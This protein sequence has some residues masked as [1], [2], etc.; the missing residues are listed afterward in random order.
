MPLRAP[1]MYGFIFGFHRLVWWPKWTPASSRF[2]MVT[3]VIRAP[4]YP[5]LLSARRSKRGPIPAR[6]ARTQLGGSFGSLVHLVEELL[7][8]LGGP[9]LV[10][11]ELHRLDRIQLGEQLAQDPDAIQHVA[12]QE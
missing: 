4:W 11:Q 9:D 12:G 1:K 6:A 2:F 8:R 10:V 5:S 3:S 7:V